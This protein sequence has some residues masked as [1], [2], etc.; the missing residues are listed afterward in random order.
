MNLFAYGTLMWPEVLESVVGRRLEGVP[1]VLEGF[2]RLCVKG[3][4]YPA[5]IEAAGYS[6]AGVLYAGLTE[7]EFQCLDTFEGEEYERID[8][9]AGGEGAKIYVISKDLRHIVDSRPWHPEQL[10]SGQ[11][12]EFCSDYKGWKMASQIRKDDEI[13]PF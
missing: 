5:A 11:L 6:V 12:A 4:H 10:T 7:Q 9:V 1:V 13:A 2:R 8:V 3:Q